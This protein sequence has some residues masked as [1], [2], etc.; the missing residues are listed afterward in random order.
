MSISD[1]TI[2]YIQVYQNFVALFNT[3]TVQDQVIRV[4]K[5]V[6]NGYTELGIFTI[7]VV[8]F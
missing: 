8:F 1:S 7:F 4:V 2:N 3:I 6:M 5:S